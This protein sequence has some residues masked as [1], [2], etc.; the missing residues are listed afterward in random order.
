MKLYIYYALG[1]EESQVLEDER[2]ILSASKNGRRKVSAA[3]LSKSL[4]LT[5]PDVNS[6]ILTYPTNMLVLKADNI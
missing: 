2:I 4:F 6:K 3:L 5:A 1:H